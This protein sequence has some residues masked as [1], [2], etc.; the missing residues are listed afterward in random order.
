M[1]LLPSSCLAQVLGLPSPLGSPTRP[2]REA[3]GLVVVWECYGLVGSRELEL[4]TCAEGQA[5]ATRSL[6]SASG[7]YTCPGACA[8]SLHPQVHVDLTL[9]VPRSLV[10]GLPP[11]LVWAQSLG[12]GIQARPFSCPLLAL[13]ECKTPELS[14]RAVA[15]GEAPCLP[16][17]RKVTMC[18]DCDHQKKGYRAR[19]VVSGD[20]GPIET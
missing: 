18:I 13:R 7:M 8:E 9:Y 14:L 15:G 11:C 5:C 12:T 19:L 3:G 1:P 16:A 17:S 4:S 10:C 20:P 6:G 2:G